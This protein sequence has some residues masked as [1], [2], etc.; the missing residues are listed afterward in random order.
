MLVL[1][2][3]AVHFMS[4]F[5]LKSSFLGALTSVSSL[6]SYAYLT[7]WEC[8]TYGKQEGLFF[9]HNKKIHFKQTIK[10]VTLH[11]E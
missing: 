8:S 5:S 3:L 2:M 11:I 7:G 9:Y 1:S 6:Y 4:C 10:P